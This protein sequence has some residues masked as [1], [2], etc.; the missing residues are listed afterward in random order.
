ME[1]QLMN[2]IHQQN[3]KALQVKYILLQWRISMHQPL[4]LHPQELQYD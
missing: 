3:L 1:L 2:F 4:E